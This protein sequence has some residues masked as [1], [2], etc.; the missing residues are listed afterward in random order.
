MPQRFGAGSL[1]QRP[2]H[3]REEGGRPALGGW[4]VAWL[5]E[6]SSKHCGDFP[7]GQEQLGLAIASHR[8]WQLEGWLAGTLLAGGPLE[9]GDQTGKGVKG[10][11]GKSTT[12]IASK[13]CDC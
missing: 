12:A 10:G 13:A 2:D 11:R 6:G 3:D 7:E 1:L 4:G 8:M 9:D 5:R